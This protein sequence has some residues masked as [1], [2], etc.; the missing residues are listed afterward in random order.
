M[1]SLPHVLVYGVF[2]AQGQIHDFRKG[3][4]GGGG[5]DKRHNKKRKLFV[6]ATV[7]VYV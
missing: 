7:N 6:T 5:S 2:L 4:G 1:C 3:G